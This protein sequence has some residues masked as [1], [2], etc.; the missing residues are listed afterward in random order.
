MLFNV[1]PL[2][3]PASRFRSP[4]RKPPDRATPL[5]NQKGSKLAQLP[6]E[7]ILLISDHLETTARTS[8]IR[9]CR[10]FH[11]LL[12][13]TLYQHIRLARDWRSRKSSRLFQTLAEHPD[14]IP[15]IRT[16]HGPISPRIITP[17]PVPKWNFF[18]KFSKGKQA[19][20]DNSAHDSVSETDA[21]K[22]AVSIYTQATNIVDLKFTDAHRWTLDP[23]L[24]PIR[25]ALSAMPLRRLTLCCCEEVSQVLRE[26]PELEELEIGWNIHG[27]EKVEKHHIPKLRSLRAQLPEAASLVPGRPVEQFHLSS[28]MIDEDFDERLFDRLSLSTGP[29][30]EFSTFFASASDAENVRLSFQVL[31]RTLPQVERLAISVGGSISAQVVRFFFKVICTYHRS[32]ESTCRFRS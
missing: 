5:E 20:S 18:E 6:Q 14:L 9:T 16:Y 12:E 31:S 29:I 15:F 21:L 24:E 19:V 28:G 32:N 25:A 2:T 22:R 4:E 26:Q 17:E 3:N 11:I 13:W 8:L 30:T 23:L 10:Y 1:F 27:A 7:I